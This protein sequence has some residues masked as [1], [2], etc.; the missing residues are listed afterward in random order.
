MP[1][2][3]TAAIPKKTDIKAA[4]ARR[5]S[6]MAHREIMALV[7]DDLKR[8]EASIL[9]NFQSKVTLIPAISNYL[10]N[11]GGKRLRPTLVLLT[12]RLFGYNGGEDHILHSTA[13][14]YIHAAT[15][16]HDDVVDSADIRRGL[17]S[18]NVK[19]GNGHSV[20]VGD[21]L[22]AKSFSLMAKSSSMEII[23][24]VS[25]ATKYLAEGEIMQ[26]INSCD[27]E[28]TEEEYLDLVYRKTGALITACCRVGALLGESTLEQR[29]AIEVYGKNVGIAFQLTDDMLDFISDEKTLGKPVGNDLAEGHIT[30]PFIQ[31]FKNADHVDRK[32]MQE[33]VKDRNLTPRNIQKIILLIEKYDGIG[34][35]AR[36]AREHVDR[37]IDALGCIEANVHRDALEGLADYITNRTT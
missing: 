12:S 13:V 26:L 5:K 32:F 18:A 17:I 3:Q 37:A 11:G 24:T 7:E 14:E 25:E 4:P 20:L 31:S 23:K 21:Y 28:V 9:K 27:P 10:T 15:L 30:L 16:L 6:V 36:L 2:N 1:S 29:K 8:V 34:Y 19:W 22:F 33:T 35:T